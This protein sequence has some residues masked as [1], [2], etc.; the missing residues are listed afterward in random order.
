MGS[1]KI[2]TNPVCQ[3]EIFLKGS[4]LFKATANY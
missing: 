3:K 2:K 4:K 1:I